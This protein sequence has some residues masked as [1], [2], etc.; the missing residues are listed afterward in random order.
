MIL[1]PLPGYFD[2]GKGL[3]ILWKL[4]LFILIPTLDAELRHFIDES[5]IYRRFS[6][7]VDWMSEMWNFGII[8]RIIYVWFSFYI[9][10]QRRRISSRADHRRFSRLA[11]HTDFLL[12]TNNAIIYIIYT[13]IQHL[14]LYLTYIYIHACR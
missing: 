14:L 13:Y 10:Q 12:K 6:E 8:K 5:S 11:E 4:F 2:S 9:C 3:L 7:T 1:R